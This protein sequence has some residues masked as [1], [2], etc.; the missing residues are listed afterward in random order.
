MG[1]NNDPKPESGADEAAR[2]QRQ[3]LVWVTCRG[4]HGTQ[5]ETDGSACGI[6]G[7]LG[8]TQTRQIG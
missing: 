6:C 1:K 7:G 3:T 5:K 4:C 2:M 8:E